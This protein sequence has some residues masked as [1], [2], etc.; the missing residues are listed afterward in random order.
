MIRTHGVAYQDAQENWHHRTVSVV[1]GDVIVGKEIDG[2]GEGGKPWLDKDGRWHLHETSTPP[3]AT[4]PAAPEQP[5]PAPAPEPT[6]PAV[7]YTLTDGDGITQAVKHLKEHWPEGVK[8][9]EWLEKLKTP[10]DYAKW[11]EDNHF[12]TPDEVKDSVI[13]YK[14]DVISVD[15]NGELKIVSSVH[16]PEHATDTLTDGRGVASPNTVLSSRDFSDSMPT[17]GGHTAS[18]APSPAPS[19]EPTPALTPEA[20]PVA[21]EHEEH[22]SPTEAETDSEDRGDSNVYEYQGYPP[23]AQYLID[24][25]FGYRDYY[26]N[27]IPGSGNDNF[28]DAY[29]RMGLTRDEYRGMNPWYKL[30]NTEEYHDFEAIKQ[31]LAAMDR[32]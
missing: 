15:S 2:E 10:E 12:Y 19:P 28:E 14:G 4:A 24:E 9:P 32:N 8:M 6:H 17:R 16:N 11:A 5:A 13:M 26:G 1:N 29:D 22:D 21:E 25:Q 20:A 18:P 30:P 31:I 23:E 27:I 7:E 3:A